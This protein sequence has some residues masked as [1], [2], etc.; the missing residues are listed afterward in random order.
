MANT[1]LPEQDAA[2]EK[3]E[4]PTIIVRLLPARRTMTLPRPKTV[5]GLL[6]RLDIPPGTALVIR[7]GGLL[8]PD[9]EIL[10]NDDVTI[11]IVTS[12]G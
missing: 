3:R 6:Q 8:T 7:D 2:P 4:P 9:R 1:S 12:S 11:R 10:P 5:L